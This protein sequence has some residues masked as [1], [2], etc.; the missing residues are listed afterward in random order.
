MPTLRIDL[1]ILSPKAALRKAAEESRALILGMAQDTG[2]AVPVRS[3]KSLKIYTEAFE[4]LGR[5]KSFEGT[6]GQV[7]ALLDHSEGLRQLPGYQHLLGLGVGKSKDFFS[8][9]ILHWAGK[10]AGQLRNLKIT[11]ADLILDT[12]WNGA[13]SAKSDSAPKDFAGR[14]SLSG[15]VSKEE[16][17]EKFALGLYLGSYRFDIYKSK[18]SSSEKDKSKKPE[19]LPR[20]RI[21]FQGIDEKK[22]QGILKRAEILAESVTLCRDL[23]TTP[24]GDLPPAELARRAQ[25]AG[26]E[27]GFAVTIFDEKKLK[28]EGMN[29]ILT[30]GMGSAEPPRF[31]ILE[32][33]AAKKSKLPTVVLVGKGIT[34]DTGGICIK[35]AAGM[36][37]MKMD[38]SGSASVVGALYALA[39]LKAPVHVVGLIASAEN[40]PGSRAVRPGDIYTAHDGQT[41]EVINTDAE[42]RLV[43]ADALSYAKKYNPDAVIDIATLTGAVL[44]ALGHAATGIMGTDKDLLEG[45][46]RASDRAGEKTWEL[47]LFE[48][49]EEQVKSKVADYKNVGNGR[50]AGSCTAGIFLKAFVQG[51]YPWIHLDVA[52]TAD[53]PRGQG[54]HCPPDVGTGVPVRALVEFAEHFDK[55][56]VPK[57]KTK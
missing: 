29:G 23:Q 52:G 5:Q 8:Q 13:E 6:G 33:N 9:N 11:D 37:E 56:F 10:L 1:E 28:T 30:V 16:F 27:A 38:M 20:V 19:R 18:K 26:T 22:A 51:A 40:M 44:V 41:V 15:L 45:F 42:G 34:F 7:H 3:A 46:R 48:D 39:K 14:P 17:L 35:P 31:M 54:A 43:L 50:E 57:K 36:E 32:H 47:P 12:L 2:K 49:Y 55:Y 53:T 4:I 25:K 21:Q 24:G